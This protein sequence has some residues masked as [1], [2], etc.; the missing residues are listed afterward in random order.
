MSHEA[1]LCVPSGHTCETYVHWLG[2]E[3]SQGYMRLSGF[4]M[5]FGGLIFSLIFPCCHWGQLPLGVS[6]S[7]ALACTITMA[8]TGCQSTHGAVFLQGRWLR[9]PAVVLER[10]ERQQPYGGP[11]ARVFCLCRVMVPRVA[12]MCASG[13]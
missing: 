6:D 2:Q 13:S 3:G 12:G 10:A 4:T 8:H 9:L 11:P 1:I 7:A 5:S